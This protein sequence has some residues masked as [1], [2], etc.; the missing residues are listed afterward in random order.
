MSDVRTSRASRRMGE[1]WILARRQGKL[2]EPN[3][4][5]RAILPSKRVERALRWAVFAGSIITG[6]ESLTRASKLECWIDLATGTGMASM[7]EIQ[8]ELEKVN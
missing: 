2:G 6:E 3:G 4:G 7:F 1:Y 8:E 5:F